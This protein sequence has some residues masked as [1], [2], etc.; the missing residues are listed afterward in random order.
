MKSSAEVAGDDL[1]A[2]LLKTKLEAPGCPRLVV[3]EDLIEA[4]S[5]N[6]S[7]PLT[8]VYGPAG[9]GKTMLVAQWQASEPKE[10]SVAWLSLDA[11]DNDPARFWI[12]VVQALRS[13]LPGF[14]EPALAMLRAPGIAVVDEAL[15]KLINELVDVTRQSALVLDDYHAI[16]DERIHQGMASLL[17]HLPNALRIVITSRAEPPLGI[18]TL[19]ARG[20]LHEVDAARLRFSRSEAESL[21]NDVH[22]LGLPA[23]MVGRLHERTEGWAAGLYLAVLS[24]RARG[25]VSSFIQSFA[26]SD[27]RVVD[28]LGAEV[29]AEQ[30]DEEVAFLLDT[31]VLDRFCAPLCEA[32]TGVRDAR[33]MLDRIE[34]SNYFLIP[35]DPSHDW[36]RYHHLFGELLRHE[37]E[38]IRPGSVAEL[39]RRA[40]RWFLDAG[41]VSDAIGHLTAAGDLEEVSEL[42]ST[43]WLSFTNVGQRATVARWLEALP[44][45]HVLS[46]GR[47]CLA[48]ARTA[49]VVGKRDEILEWVDLAERAPTHNPAEDAWIAEQATVLRSTAW[50]MLGDMGASRQLAARLAPLDG[51]SF[52]HA[53]AAGNLGAAA[54]WLDD[55]SEAVK[56][57]DT[58]LALNRDRIAMV[59][60]FAL[61]QLALI[62]A[63]G[64]DWRACADHVE[65]G[66]DLVRTRGLEEYWQCSLLHAAHG[67]LLHHDRRLS[68]ARS[69]LER[70]AALARRGVGLVELAYILLT[71]GDLLYELGDRR[72]VRE[73]VLE[74]REL[75]SSAPEPGTL[76]PRLLGKAESR[77]R[78]VLLASGARSVVTDELTPREQAVL[79]LL[80]T[81][82]SAREIGSELGVSRD[83]IKTHTKSI[84]RKLGAS[85]RR[86]AV[87][88][89]RELE[90]L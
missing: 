73:L 70:A 55:N 38:R 37:L 35:L 69:E 9:S 79:H 67:R 74:A 26:G 20:Q 2:P 88:R 42:I 81:G 50:E 1:V 24:M 34:R 23:E 45:E 10:C 77:L 58:A 80:P 43:N 11:G 40:G 28:Y 6:L 44:R 22:D 25:D 83:T 39:H 8:L 13:V 71:L 59:S 27:R 84:Y 4:L 30:P 62:A 16:D 63:E 17:E 75:L 76:V 86:D 32:V 7:L 41:L 5:E 72:T 89:A 68:E 57:F 66:F 87:A 48:R 29:L 85:S 60:V 46:D 82:L 56:L 78:L 51:S 61:G 14:G 3:R 54:H 53:L 90:L 64:G 33:A 15:L 52:W 18:G 47:L 36:Y 21:L 49:S 12:Y 65:A 19:R 31:S